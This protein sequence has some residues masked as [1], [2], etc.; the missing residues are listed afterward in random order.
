MTRVLCATVALG[1]IT[2]VMVIIL[3]TAVKTLPDDPMVD[4]GHSMTL[5]VTTAVTKL[6]KPSGDA[7]TGTLEFMPNVVPAGNAMTRLSVAEKAVAWV[8]CTVAVTPSWSADTLDSLMTAAEAAEMVVPSFT[9]A[10]M[11]M[12]PS[13]TSTP[14]KVVVL[15]LRLTAALPA[16]GKVT[17]EAENVM[18]IATALSAYEPTA[19]WHVMSREPSGTKQSK[20]VA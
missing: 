1:L 16:K 18:V 3:V 15:I 20:A 14:S 12:V 9:T 2:F 10:S 7:H 17:V 4:K 19:S 13:A 6:I 11:S 5:S 8:N